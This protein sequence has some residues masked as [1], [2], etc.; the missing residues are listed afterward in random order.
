MK[1]TIISSPSTQYKILEELGHNYEG[2]RRTLKALD[3]ENHRLV[4]IKQFRFVTSQQTWNN[5]KVIQRE[6]EV[7]RHLDHS[8]IPDYLESFEGEKGLY[9]VQEYK[10]AKSLNQLRSFSIEETEHIAEQILSILVYLQKQNPPIF[11]RDIKPENILI[12]EIP[13]PAT[14]K[15]EEMTHQS[16]SSKEESIRVYLVDFGLAKEGENPSAALSSVMVG[17]PGFMSPEQLLNKPLTKSSDLYGLGMTLICLLTGKKSTEIEQ[18]VNDDFTINFR[19]YVKNLSHRLI[20][21]LEK[22]VQ[23]NLKDRFESAEIALSVLN[24]LEQFPSPIIKIVPSSLSFKCDQWGKIYSQTLRVFDCTTNKIIQG[25]WEVEPH[26]SDPPHTPEHH[27]WISIIP[28]KSKGHDQTYKVTINTKKIRVNQLYGRQIRFHTNSLE[29]LTS[30]TIDV[31]VQKIQYLSLFLA[32]KYV[33]WLGLWLG[34]T[35]LII[36][37]HSETLPDELYPFYV[38]VFTIVTFGLSFAP[39]I[40]LWI[41]TDGFGYE[42]YRYKNQMLSLI[43]LL[44]S[45]FFSFVIFVFSLITTIIITAL[46]SSLQAQWMILAGIIATGMTSSGIYILT[47]N[48]KFSLGLWL[49]GSLG[50]ILGVMIHLGSPIWLIIL[51]TLGSFGIVYYFSMQTR[52]KYRRLERQGK[53]IKS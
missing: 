19:P 29:S 38:L 31:F 1:N 46:I 24:Q 53:L 8:H 27:D 35:L 17:T 50:V 33:L 5:L 15:N 21:W 2:G 52:L 26:L 39:L 9:L 44:A 42:H 22:M 12:E 16:I 41:K 14:V 20:Q 6:I 49:S 11:H 34:I 48:K 47:S 43:L 45:F 51:L 30:I 25:K 18:L 4:V 40:I 13:S 28:Q 3:L 32:L 36:S 23:P 37:E 10:E 7:L